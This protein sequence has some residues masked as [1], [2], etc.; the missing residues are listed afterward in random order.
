MVA[1]VGIQNQA[2]GA[3]SAVSQGA[4]EGTTTVGSITGIDSI[5]RQEQTRAMSSD[6][7][8]RKQAANYFQQFV[9]R[10]KYSS[11]DQ[12]QAMDNLLDK[13][14][15]SPDGWTQ[16]ESMQFNVLFNDAEKRELHKGA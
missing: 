14:K 12:K 4:P 13:L 6:P 15:T 9:D 11:P 2:S 1:A 16:N 3:T 10:L 8:T 7:D 5:S